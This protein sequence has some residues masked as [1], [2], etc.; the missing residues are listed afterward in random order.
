M[1][2]TV[3]FTVI[4]TLPYGQGHGHEPLRRNSSDVQP[5][6]LSPPLPDQ[7]DS[8]SDNRSRS[9]DSKK[10]SP[11]NSDNLSNDMFF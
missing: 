10:Y 3:I 6:D 1:L 5:S 8:P 9:D 11:D 7:P 2:W 4:A